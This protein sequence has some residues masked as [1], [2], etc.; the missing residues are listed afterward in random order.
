MLPAKIYM[1]MM[2]TK[3][4]PLHNHRNASHDSLPTP[5]TKHDYEI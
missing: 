1:L 3:T 5:S 2:T 4:A